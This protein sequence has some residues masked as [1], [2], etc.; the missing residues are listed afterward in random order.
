M[1]TIFNLV[2]EAR[3][4]TGQAFSS[5]QSTKVCFF[6]MLLV[7]IAQRALRGARSPLIENSVLELRNL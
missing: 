2:I 6:H 3:N 4:L 7:T 5:L 1:A